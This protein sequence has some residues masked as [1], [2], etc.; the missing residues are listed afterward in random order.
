MALATL[1]TVEDFAGCLVGVWVACAQVNSTVRELTPGAMPLGGESRVSSV[2]AAI[3]F[4]IARRSLADRALQI[5]LCHI[6][7]AL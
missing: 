6:E 1:N 7:Y 3:R 2:V 5:V 4:Q